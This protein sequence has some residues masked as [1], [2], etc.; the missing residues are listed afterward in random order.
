MLTATSSVMLTA[1][2]ASSVEPPASAPDPVI[3]TRTVTVPQCPEELRATVPGVPQPA[4]DAVITGNDAG[5]G[6][7]GD[8][9]AHAELLTRRLIDAASSCP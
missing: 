2:A 1:C 3:E 7:L 9:L 6:W 8:V 5:V 4:D